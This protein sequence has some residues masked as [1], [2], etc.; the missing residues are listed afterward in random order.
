MNGISEAQLT[1]LRQEYDRLR[2]STDLT[3]VADA[4]WR[5]AQQVARFEER[6]DALRRDQYVFTASLTRSANEL[7]DRWRST[8][9]EF[10]RV[11]RDVR[12][13]VGRDVDRVEDAIRYAEQAPEV[14]RIG[15]AQNELQLA[16]G[17]LQD[18]ERRLRLS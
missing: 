8:E 5:L 14:G 12:Y 15:S 4:V 2:R 16:L 6:I 3:S 17:R 9:A 7:R 18:A 1:A 13:D 11:M 10:D